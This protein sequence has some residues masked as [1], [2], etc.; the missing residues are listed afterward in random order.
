[1]S[2]N[3]FIQGG[4]MNLARI[5]S[6]LIK[7]KKLKYCG[8]GDEFEEE[9]YN[10]LSKAGFK[11]L[12]PFNKKDSKDRTKKV[13]HFLENY[14]KE[15]HMVFIS[16]PKGTHGC[17][18]YWIFFNNKKIKIECKSSKSG[19]I[20]WNS[21]RPH[22]DIMYAYNCYKTDQTYLFLGQDHIGDMTKF[23]E[24]IMPDLK[25]IKKAL[26]EELNKKIVSLGYGEDFYL[27]PRTDWLDKT[28]V[29]QQYTKKKKFNVYKYIKEVIT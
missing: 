14:K 5:M 16:Q 23:N 9:V 11:E 8:G 10:V 7:I 22:N 6:T 17:P 1:M 28:K 21:G 25:K 18:D 27:N 24:E 4:I 29:S 12:I 13:N 3:I 26:R 19:S 20:K 15:L 2:Y